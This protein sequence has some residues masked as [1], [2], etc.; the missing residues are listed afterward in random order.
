MDAAL[1]LAR[2][3]ARKGE[4]PVG[5]V[6]VSGGRIVGRGANRPIAARDPTAHAEVVALRRAAR[7]ARNHRLAGATLYVTL[8][9]CLMCLGAMLHA[10][11]ERLVFG[12]EDPKVGSTALLERGLPGLNHRFETSGGVHARECADLLRDFFQAR[13]R[14]GTAAKAPASRVRRAATVSRPSGRHTAR[15]S[16]VLSRRR[17]RAR[18]RRAR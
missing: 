1:R 8:E 14:Q 4:V 2:A 16:A 6:V 17:P 9:P 18:I 12:A 5:C 13:R 11:I 7:A 10:R 3:A 15:R